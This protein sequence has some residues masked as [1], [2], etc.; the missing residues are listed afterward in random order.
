MLL[1]QAVR[2]KYVAS[3]HDNHNNNKRKETKKLREN[4]RE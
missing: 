1:K 2:I 4:V 3:T